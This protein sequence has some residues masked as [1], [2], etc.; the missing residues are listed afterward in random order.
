MLCCAKATTSRDKSPERF[1][2][3][4]SARVKSRPGSKA[5]FSVKMNKLGAGSQVNAFWVDP[6][7]GHQEPIGRLSNTGVHSFTTPEGWED[8][9]LVLEVAGGA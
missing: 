5:E 1:G 6:R 3:H 8:A 7:D 4:P 9:L 2:N